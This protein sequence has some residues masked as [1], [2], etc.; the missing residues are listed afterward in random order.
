LT[1]IS[2]SGA[3]DDVYVE[4][5]H[6]FKPEEIV[7]LTFAIVTINNWNRLSVGFGTDS[8]NYTSHKRPM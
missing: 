3:P 7:E 8:G 6:L 5:E 1:F 2:Q 4:L